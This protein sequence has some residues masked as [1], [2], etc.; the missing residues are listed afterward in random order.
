MDVLN[1]LVTFLLESVVDK[2]LTS[3]DSRMFSAVLEAASTG[4]EFDISGEQEAPEKYSNYYHLLAGIGSLAR[5]HYYSSQIADMVEYLVQKMRLRWSGSPKTGAADICNKDSASLFIKTLNHESILDML[6]AD[7]ATQCD[8][9]RAR[10][11]NIDKD[12][13]KADSESV[14]RILCNSG[15][16]GVS[17]KEAQNSASQVK[18]IRARV[19]VDWEAQ[20][21]RDSMLAPYVNVDQ[22]RAALRDGL[23]AHSSEQQ[24]GGPGLGNHR[25][26]VTANSNISKSSVYNPQSASRVATA[27]SVDGSAAIGDEFRGNDEYLD[28]HGQPVPDDV[29]DLLDSID[30]DDYD[31]TTSIVNEFPLHALSESRDNT[32]SSS[33]ISTPVIGNVE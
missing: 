13:W 24:L 14:N 30:I 12:Y 17:T 10:Q 5:H 11:G 21:R 16:G 15:D 28:M 25:A 2:Q 9:L 29:R 32:H 8:N 3:P 18:D 26:R 6:G 4:S 31:A 7:I 23:S 1:V 33:T 22:L 19:S 27:R 20:V